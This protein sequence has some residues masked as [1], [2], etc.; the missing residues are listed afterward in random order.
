VSCCCCCDDDDGQWYCSWT[1][2]ELHHQCSLWSLCVSVAGLWYSL[3]RLCD[4]L[5]VSDAAS[6]TN[7]QICCRHFMVL[8]WQLSRELIRLV[9]SSCWYVHICSK[10]TVCLYC[11]QRMCH[12]VCLDSSLLDSDKTMQACNRTWHRVRCCSIFCLIFVLC[13]D[14]WWLYSLDILADG[15]CTLSVLQVFSWDL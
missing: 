13:Q 10:Y 1:I 11:W 3:Q 2:T 15:L 5:Q 6:A 4:V 9:R 7:W 12:A 14:V 8:F